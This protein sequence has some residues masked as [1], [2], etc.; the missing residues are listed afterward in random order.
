[1]FGYS[2]EL[3]LNVEPAI[4][5]ELGLVG[6]E[7]TW[8][9]ATNERELTSRGLPSKTKKGGAQRPMSWVLTSRGL[10]Y[11]SKQSGAQGLMSRELTSRG[12]HDVR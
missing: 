4:H 5:N 3:H 1:M 11:E 10:P 6:G 7:A 12:L 2:L 8:R 9:A